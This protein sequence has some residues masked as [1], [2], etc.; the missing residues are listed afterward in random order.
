MVYILVL[1]ISYM[2]FVALTAVALL[3]GKLAET[4]VVYMMKPVF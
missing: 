4:V 1:F 3:F 2:L